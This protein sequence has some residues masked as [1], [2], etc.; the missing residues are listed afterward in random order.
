MTMGCGGYRSGST[1][2]RQHRVCARRRLPF[3][4]LQ[5]PLHVRARN[6]GGRGVERGIDGDTVVEEGATIVSVGEEELCVH[7]ELAGDDAWGRGESL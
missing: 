2:N 3:R 6:F 4:A 1:K 5:W 7:D